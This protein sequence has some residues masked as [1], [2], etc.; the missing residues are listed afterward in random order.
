MEEKTQAVKNLLY[1]QQPQNRETPAASM[2]EPAPGPRLYG[3]KSV[4][5]QT[6]GEAA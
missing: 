6:G 4:P 1:Q 5:K 2:R 3:R